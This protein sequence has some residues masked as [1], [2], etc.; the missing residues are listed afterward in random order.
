VV[1]G[2][3]EEYAASIFNPE[4]GG[5]CSSKTSVS[6]CKITQPHNPEDP[7]MNSHHRENFKQLGIMTAAVTNIKMA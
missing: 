6:A 1:T 5:T 3:L 7:S 2:I 4:D